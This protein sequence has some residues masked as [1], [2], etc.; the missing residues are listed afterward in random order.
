MLLRTARQETSFSATTTSTV[1]QRK[2]DCPSSA[3]IL[4][5]LGLL[6]E[7][8]ENATALWSILTRATP[9]RAWTLLSATKVD[10][11]TANVAVPFIYVFI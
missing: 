2:L 4:L 11:A 5:L 1:A 3:L 7:F 8:A 10:T 6:I 9:L